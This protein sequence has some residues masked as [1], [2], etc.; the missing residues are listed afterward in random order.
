MRS[1]WRSGPCF[2]GSAA[3]N[4]VDHRPYSAALTRRCAT[5]GTTVSIDATLLFADVSGYTALT[6]R[7]AVLGRAGAEAVTV[8][9]NRCFELLVG[10]VLDQRGDVLRF[11]GD[12]LFVAFEG[13]DRVARAVT[14]AEAMQRVIASLPPVEVPG[15]AVV[16]RQ[17]IGVHDGRVVMHRW[18]GSWV[19][20]VPVGAA[21]SEVLRN[22]AGAGAGEVAISDTVAAG[23]PASRVRRVADGSARLRLRRGRDAASAALFDTPQ[24]DIAVARSVLPQALRGAVETPGLAEH[25]PAAIGFL[26]IGGMDALGAA[27]DR[28][29]AVIDPVLAALDAMA[30]T[31]GVH[32][33]A[34]DVA[35]DS[36]KLILAAGVPTT[37][38]DDGERL[39]TMLLRL[40]DV[41]AAHDVRAGAHLGVVFAGDVGHPYR[42]T[43]TV[44]GD[45]VN[46]AA[47]LAVHAPRG[48]LLASR[49]LIDALPNGVRV[50]EVG[51]IAVKGKRLAQEAGIVR[52][53]GTR[54]VF[55]ELQVDATMHGRARDVTRLLDSIDHNVVT[56]LLTERGLGA[57]RLVREVAERSSRGGRRGIIAAASVA[58]RAAPLRTLRRI[59][60]HLGGD[61]AWRSLDTDLL[62]VAGPATSD[63]AAASARR[64]VEMIDAISRRVIAC[65]PMDALLAI[66]NGDSMDEATD[67]VLAVIASVL[68]TNGDGRRLL[69]VGRSPRADMGAATV[70]LARLDDDAT[71]RVVID[72]APLPLSDAQIDAIVAAASGN[73]VFAIELAGSPAGSEL[74]P[75]IESLVAARIDRLPAPL[76]RTLREVATLGSEVPFAAAADVLGVDAAAL[77]RQLTEQRIPVGA[78]QRVFRIGDE[79]LRVIAMA[80]LPVSRRRQLHRRMA[81]WL[82][83]TDDP[84]PGDVADHWLAARDDLGVIRWAPTAAA[85]ARMVGATQ[86]AAT[87]LQAAIDASMRTLAAPPAIA[88]LA[89]QLAADAR[90]AGLLDVEAAALEVLVEV[91]EP[92]HRSAVYIDRAANARRRGAPRSAVGLLSHAERLAIP[93]DHQLRSRLLVERAWQAV[94]RS[95]WVKAA[96]H[97]KRALD[98]ATASGPAVDYEVVCNAWSVIEQVRNATGGAGGHDAA[99]QALRYA[100]LAGDPRCLG[101]AIGNLAMG[102]DSR[103]NWQEAARGYRRALGLFHDAGDVVNAAVSSV[104]LA[105]ILVELGDV[106][107]AEGSALGAARAFAAAGVLDGSRQIAESFVVR[108]RLR[109]GGL[110]P[111]T[112][113]SLLDRARDLVV[114]ITGRDGEIGAFHAC[115]LVEMLLLSGRVEEAVD[116]ARAMLGDAE[117][118]GS[119][120]LVPATLRRLLVVGLRL[121]G[122]PSWQ[123][124]LAEALDRASR[125]GIEPELAAL[126][127]VQSALGS[128]TNAGDDPAG[129]AAADEGDQ[130]LGICSRPWYGP[131]NGRTDSRS[132]PGWQS[133]SK[134][135]S[136][137][138]DSD[139]RDVAVDNG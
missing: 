87:W 112:I 57:S 41:G 35:V 71:R 65:W 46:L 64:W 108:A 96:A 55:G 51:S 25:R 49:N 99:L 79:T 48:S 36:V 125:S 117:R 136:S 27:P 28:L 21:V 33:L 137:G 11:G 88:D 130:R 23:L 44:M 131:L 40:L 124:M 107:E 47:R 37:L 39:V 118:F 92:A 26:V 1:D 15:G 121:R 38:G 115:G 83:S 81:E 69:L 105:S 113:D 14:A 76:R 8:A 34:T 119:E 135:R 128:G 54:R 120:H 45:A 78:T 103:G 2:A 60:E 82:E 86:T 97:A 139:D 63:A 66:D 52:A 90:L 85:R 116:R 110:A 106:D 74:R 84:R 3:M 80:G 134:P 29:A 104:S 61:D 62:R 13:N 10:C 111:E 22:E 123:S 12:A 68:R 31:M 30:S 4:P 77:A 59:V 109:R 5:G 9:V 32:L 98:A 24:D 93:E 100:Q 132:E 126:R 7:L 53:L 138:A 102:A 16:L 127:A 70:M 129:D 42:R 58:D 67:A 43:Y 18:A 122:D 20:V 19:E 72:A 89:R 50:E 133:Q 17:S 101:V 94:W 73:P 91:V 56:H 95:Q 114:D 75:S 6:E